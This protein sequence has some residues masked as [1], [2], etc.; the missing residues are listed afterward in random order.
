MLSTGFKLVFSKDKKEMIIV[1]SV[2]YIY[3][4]TFSPCQLSLVNFGGINKI[5]LLY[6]ILKPE[7]ETQRALK[8]KMVSMRQVRWTVIIA[9]AVMLTTAVNCREPVL[10]RVGGK[11]GWTYNNVNYTQWS[12][13]E[14]PPFYVGDWLRKYSLFFNIYACTY[15]LSFV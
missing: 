3:K 6:T 1:P 12:L 11:F 10:H 9:A 7:W 2:A 15:C 4:F 14:T 5:V 8:K 13:E